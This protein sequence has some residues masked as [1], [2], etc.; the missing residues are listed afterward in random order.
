LILQGSEKGREI[1]RE[2]SFLN[3]LTIEKDIKN[4]QKSVDKSRAVQYYNTNKRNELLTQIQEV[5]SRETRENVK[6]IRFDCKVIL[7]GG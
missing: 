1:Q 5:Y 4:F 2:K 7:Y 3:F 6:L